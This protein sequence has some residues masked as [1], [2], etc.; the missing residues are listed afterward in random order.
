[1]YVKM[2]DEG[3]LPIGNYKKDKIKVLNP[4][5]KF[6]EKYWY[7]SLGVEI[8]EKTDIKL[9]NESVGVDLGIKMQVLI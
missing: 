5:V 6:N 3:R 2:K 9:T 7:L 4:R 8:E 1:G